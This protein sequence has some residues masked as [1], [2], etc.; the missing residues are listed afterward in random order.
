MP[1]NRKGEKPEI[2]GTKP[3][4]PWLN[5]LLQDSVITKAG[6]AVTVLRFAFSTSRFLKL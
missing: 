1:W 6:D 2:K 5:I 4:F 3:N